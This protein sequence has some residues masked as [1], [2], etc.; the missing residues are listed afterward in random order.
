MA[1]LY[2]ATRRDMVIGKGMIS[3]RMG[4]LQDLVVNADMHLDL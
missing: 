1:L 3:P 2:G 4:L